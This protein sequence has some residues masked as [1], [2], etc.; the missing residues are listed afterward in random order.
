M[1]TE[2]LRA[3]APAAVVLLHIVVIASLDW[4]F[5]HIGSNPPLPPVA[6]ESGGLV[7]EEE[8]RK[9]QQEFDKRLPE[10]QA[11]ELSVAQDA[12]FAAYL[13]LG[14]ASVVVGW[15]VVGRARGEPAVLVASGLLVEFALVAGA[16]TLV[17]VVLIGV[18]AGAGVF[19]PS[20]ARQG[21]SS[22][23]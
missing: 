19:L 23:R 20:R 8:M 18:G 11:R 12:V 1:I 16:Y 5:G 4:S 14:A 22:R 9:R 2:R 17:H 3:C 15:W 13:A 10:R 7:T 21:E 6:A